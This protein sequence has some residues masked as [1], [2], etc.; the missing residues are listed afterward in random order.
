MA[1]SLCFEQNILSSK[2]NELQ[3]D[4]AVQGDEELPFADKD[5]LFKS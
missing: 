3:S 2:S 1:S 5:N 4:V